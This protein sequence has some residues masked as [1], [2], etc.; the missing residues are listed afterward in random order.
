MSALRVSQPGQPTR[1][2][3]DRDPYLGLTQR[4]R[5]ILDIVRSHNGNRARAARQ[6]GVSTAAVQAVVRIA[7]KAGVVMPVPTRGP[8]LK[9]RATKPEPCGV[10]MERSAAPCGRGAGHRGYHRIRDR[11]LGAA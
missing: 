9:P 7:A 11:R 2:V 3:E 6:L 8:D 5:H 4:Q 10:L 1:L